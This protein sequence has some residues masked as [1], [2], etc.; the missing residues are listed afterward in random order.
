MNKPRTIPRE[1]ALIRNQLID[2]AYGRRV[3]LPKHDDIEKLAEW[4]DTNSIL[5]PLYE[6]AE[7]GEMIS[8]NLEYLFSDEAIKDEEGVE[9]EINDKLRI[10]FIRQ[11]IDLCEESETQLFTLKLNNEVNE[12][13]YLGGS[14]LNMGQ[15]GWDWDFYGCYKSI[16]LFEKEI[17]KDKF[18]FG[19][20]MQKLSDTELLSLWN[21][22]SK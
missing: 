21:K 20:E 10:E 14:V 7:W 16:E 12:E 6:P 11:K 8:P 2:I 9:I 22:T 19:Y 18:L 15:G 1:L 17:H 3:N 5:N 4:I 13:V